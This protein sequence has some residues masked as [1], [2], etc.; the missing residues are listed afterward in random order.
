[1]S[2]DIV[3]SSVSSLYHHHE[4]HQYRDFFYRYWAGSGAQL[5]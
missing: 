4:V 5:S 3:L 2:A 1:M